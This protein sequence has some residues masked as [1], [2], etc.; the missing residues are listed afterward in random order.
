MGCGAAG[1]AY[2]AAKRRKK[3]GEEVEE[4][5]PNL[6][7]SNN[8]SLQVQAGFDRGP[9]SLLKRELMMK[10]KKIAEALGLALAALAVAALCTWIAAD[11]SDKAEIAQSLEGAV[12]EESEHEE[13]QG[14]GLGQLVPGNRRVGGSAQYEHKPAGSQGRQAESRTLISAWMRSAKEATAPHT[15]TPTARK[16]RSSSRST[17][18]TCPTAACSRFREVQRGRLRAKPFAHLPACP[19]WRHVR[20]IGHCRWTSW[21][22]APRRC[23]Q[24]LTIRGDCAVGW[25]KRPRPT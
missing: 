14:I 4:R 23:A 7:S 9:P 1:A 11:D 17:G 5:P 15:S 12:S 2:A 10:L 25:Q 8:K 19:R 6:P 21:T 22:P 3:A 20:A 18:T 24:A 16:G 13:P